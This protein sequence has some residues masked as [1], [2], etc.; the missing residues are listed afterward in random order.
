MLNLISLMA[1]TVVENSQALI[2]SVAPIMIAVAVMLLKDVGVKKELKEL[3]VV[4]IGLGKDIAI[5]KEITSRYRDNEAYYSAICDTVVEAVKYIKDEDTQI[6]LNSIS[7]SINSFSRVILNTDVDKINRANTE[8]HGVVLKK[9]ILDYIHVNL[10]TNMINESATM[11]GS[12]IDLYLSNISA[13][14]DDIVNDKKK[15]FRTETMR[16]MEIMCSE[17]V[18]LYLHNAN[19]PKGVN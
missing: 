17:F 15:R 18:N 4:V 16:L 8:L 6:F 14:L 12:Q 9:S 1:A 3:K 5:N 7:K 11:I 2:S 10:N 19:S 13:M